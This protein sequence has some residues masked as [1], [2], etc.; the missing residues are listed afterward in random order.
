M[1]S[2]LYILFSAF[3]LIVTAPQLPAS[4][5]R[6][7]TTQG[8]PTAPYQC[9][10]AATYGGTVEDWASSIQQTREGGYIVAGLAGSF[11][12]GKRSLWVLKLRPDASVEWQKAYG[13]LVRDEAKSIRQTGDGGYIVAGVTRSFGVWEADMW[14]LKLRP[15]GAVEWQKAYG[16]V[17]RDEA[18]SIQQTGDGGYI[19]AGYTESFGAGK[20]DFWV[21]KLRSDGAVEWQ[22]TYGGVDMDGASSI[23]QTGDGGYIVAGY[24]RSFDAGGGDF[25]VLKLAP[26]GSV[27]WQKAYGGTDRDG[28]GAGSIRQTRDGGYIVAGATL[29]FDVGDS[30][31]WVLKLK[32]NGTIEWQ[33]TYGGAG[34]DRAESI[35]Q[36]GDGGYI[37]AGTTGSFGAG[38][39]DFFVL[40]LESDG[41]IEWQKAYGGAD[42]DW[43]S[44]IQQTREG[45]YIVT[46][47]TKSFGAGG[48]A[49]WVLKLRPDGYICPSCDVVFDITASET[50]SNATILDTRASVKDSHADPHDSSAVIM[51]TYAPAEIQCPIAPYYYGKPIRFQPLSIPQKTPNP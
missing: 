15:D 18:L 16:G 41:T 29:S 51:D 2:L 43:A 10:W 26:D 19:V 28:D 23:Q 35:R 38:K 25:W 21:I 24:T 14:V 17:A 7:D 1:H 48:F 49:F 9:G 4:D 31:L 34:S 22:K 42:L 45:G 37:V 40:K 12:V 11:G 39:D 30:D 20:E 13:G 33:N 3:F 8:Q 6:Q 36:T 46:G 5:D 32:S 44:S 50:R 27:E 47:L